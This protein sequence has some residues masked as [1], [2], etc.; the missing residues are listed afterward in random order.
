MTI[1][2]AARATGARDVF[3]LR[4]LSGERYFNVDGFGRGA[5]WAGVVQLER[6][7]EPLVQKAL[8]TGVARRSSGVPFRAFGPYWATDVAAVASGEDVVVFGG[9]S[10]AGASD[11]AL[12]EAASAI[13]QVAGDVSSD[14][15]RADEE[16][17]QGAVAAVEAIRGETVEDAAAAVAAEAAR[18]L[19]CEFGAVLLYGPPARV[20]MADEG[21]RPT[22]TDEEV[23]AALLPLRAVLREGMYVEQD[24]G[25]SRFAYPPLGFRDGL[26]A[27]CAVEIGDGDS[28]GLLVVAH[29]AAA[30]RGFTM[31]CRRVARAIGERAADVLQPLGSD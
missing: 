9:G 28:A 18:A 13:A 7:A 3:F 16:E 31:L 8:E 11:A 1:A 22:A 20:V 26:V 23:I 29:A 12:Q 2:E 27:R 5:G 15:R 24:A 25:T 10:V 14:K 4:K 19:S 6:G 30:P 21:W 17:V